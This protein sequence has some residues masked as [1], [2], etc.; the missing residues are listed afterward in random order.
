[1]ECALVVVKRVSMEIETPKVDIIFSYNLQPN[2][3]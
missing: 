1:M 3:E 2:S